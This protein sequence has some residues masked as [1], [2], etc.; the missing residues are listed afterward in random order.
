MRSGKVLGDLALEAA[1]EEGTQL[2]RESAAGNLERGG[3]GPSGFVLLEEVGLAA[4]VARLHEV[5]DAPQV[6]QAVLQGRAGEGQALVDVQLFHRLSDLGRGVLDKLGLVQ[7]HG[8]EGELL[9][10]G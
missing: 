8:A 10:R 2:G 4:K 7:D 6:E 9:E 3:I 5:H 1:Q